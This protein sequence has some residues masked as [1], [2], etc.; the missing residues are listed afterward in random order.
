MSG[1]ANLPIE[2][3]VSV[4]KSSVGVAFADL[5]AKAASAGRKIGE[6]LSTKVSGTDSYK[7]LNTAFDN[8]QKNVA[9]G[10]AQ[11]NSFKTSEAKRASAIE[12]AQYKELNAAFDSYQKNVAQGVAQLNALKI[13]EAKKAAQAEIQAAKEVQA[14]LKEA[15]NSSTQSAFKAT[16]IRSPQDVATELAALRETKKAWEAMG[17]ATEG[18]KGQLDAITRSTNI[19]TEGN[20]RARGEFHQ[21]VAQLASWTFEVTA[22]AWALKNLGMAIASPALAGGKYLKEL[23]D[24]KLGITGVLMAMGHIDGQ[25]L[26]FGQASEVAEGQ[27]KLLSNEAM[28]LAGNTIDLAKAFQAVAVQGLEAGMTIDQIRT[29]AVAGTAAGRALGISAQTL[30]RDIRD[31]VLGIRPNSTI[32]SASLGITKADIDSARTSAGGLFEYLDGK[33]K[34]FYSAAMERNK[35]FSGMWEQMTEML[36]RALGGSSIEVFQ[37]AKDLVLQ[38]SDAIGKVDKNTHEFTVNPEF[39]SQLD[40]IIGLTNVL[41]KIVGAIAKF[42]WDMKIPLELWAGV[43]V[44]ITAWSLITTSITKATVALV[45]Y[46]TAQ[47]ASASVKAGTFVGPMQPLSSATSAATLASSLASVASKVLLVAAVATALYEIEKAAA[48]AFPPLQKLNDLISDQIDKFMEWGKY[49]TPLPKT[50]EEIDTALTKV[51]VTAVQDVAQAASTGGVVGLFL[52]F[53]AAGKEMMDTSGLEAQKKALQEASDKAATF[54]G[55]ITGAAKSVATL[56][57]ALKSLGDPLASAAD[58]ESKYLV[59]LQA[60]ARTKISIVEAKSRLEGL[61]QNPERDVSAVQ[62][63]QKEYN[64][65]I[66]SYT[67]AQ[68]TVN[69]KTQQSDLESKIASTNK[70]DSETAKIQLEYLNKRA[71]LEAKLVE[72][73]DMTVAQK[74]KKILNGNGKPMSSSDLVNTNIARQTAYNDALSETARIQ[75]LIDAN[76]AQEA[77]AI[78]NMPKIPRSPYKAELDKMSTVGIAANIEA[79]KSRTVAIAEGVSTN[80]AYVASQKNSSNME[81]VIKSGILGRLSEQQK[82]TLRQAAAAKDWEENSLK[83]VNAEQEQV[84]AIFSKEGAINQVD[85]IASKYF[86]TLSAGDQISQEF[87]LS[88]EKIS[89]PLGDAL[90]ILI[91]MRDAGNSSDGLAQAIAAI[92]EKLTKLGDVSNYVTK[93]LAPMLEIMQKIDQLKNA[94]DIKIE[95]IKQQ[96]LDLVPGGPQDRTPIEQ[97]GI[98]LSIYEA[99]NQLLR[100]TNAELEKMKALGVDTADVTSKQRKD[101]DETA[102]KVAS[103]RKE[104]EGY[105][106]AIDLSKSYGD[107]LYKIFDRAGSLFGG[108]AKPI[109]EVARSIGNLAGISETYTKSLE[110]AK[111]ISDDVHDPKRIEVEEA[112]YKKMSQESIGAYGDLAASA[113]GFFDNNSKGYSAMMGISK[114]F[115]MAE[116]AMQLATIPSKIMAGAAT[117]FGQSGWGGFV[118]VAAMGVVMAGLGYAMSGGSGGGAQIPQEDTAAYQQKTQGTGTVLGDSTAQSKTIT[119]GIEILSK[120]SFEMLD[121]TQSMLSALKRIDEG[122]SNLASSLAKISGIT[123]IGGVS[124]FGTVEKSSS[125]AGFLGIGATTDKTEIINTGILI[126]GTVDALTNLNGTIQQ[127]ETTAHSWSDS[128]FLGIGADSGVDINTQTKAITGEAVTQIGMIFG[129]MSDSI[130]EGINLLGMAANGSELEALMTTIG[131]TIIKGDASLMGL[132]GKDLTDA[133]NGVFSKAFDDMVGAIMPYAKDFQKIGEGIGETFIRLASNARTVD[134]A[135]TSMGMSFPSVA[136]YTKTHMPTAVDLTAV[137]NAQAKRDAV[138]ARLSASQQAD[139]AATPETVIGYTLKMGPSDGLDVFQFDTVMGKVVKASELTVSS[140]KE[141]IDADKDLAAAHLAAGDTTID[142]SHKLMIAREYLIEGAGGIDKFVESAQFFADKFLSESERLKPIAES[143]KSAFG[144]MSAADTA[145]GHLAGLGLQLKTLG[146]EVPT[147]KEEFKNI[148]LSLDLT[149]QSGADLYNS[150]MKVAP[151]FDAVTEAAKAFLE[152]LAS[153]M[154]SFS[155]TMSSFRGDSMIPMHQSE[156]DAAFVKLNKLAPW[157]KSIQQLSTITSADFGN[158]SEEAR[159]AILATLKA[160]DTLKNDY[161]QATAQASE[162]ATQ[163][164]QAAKDAYK[165]AL[166]SQQ[167]YFV[168][169]VDFGKSIKTFLDQLE[170]NPNTAISPQ[171]QLEAARNQYIADLTKAKAGDYEAAKN[172]TQTAQTYIDVAKS[173]YGNGSEQSAILSQI[174]AELNAL[175][176]VAQYDANLA[177][178]NSLDAKLVTLDNSTATVNTSINTIGVMITKAIEVS[179]QVLTSAYSGTVSDTQAAGFTFNPA[180]GGYNWDAMNSGS[181]GWS[182]FAQTNAVDPINFMPMHSDAYSGTVSDTQAAANLAAR[183]AINRTIGSAPQFASGGDFT[184]GVRLVGEYGPELEITGPSRIYSADQTRNLLTKPN[185]N[186]SEDIILE[187][188]MLR[189][190]L[191]ETKITLARRLEQGNSKISEQTQELSSVMY[192]TSNSVV[193]GTKTAALLKDTA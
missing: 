165:S 137:T 69:L 131:N 57:D 3:T 161:A 99:R 90:A 26:T 10:V 149:S 153:D 93:T 97:S 8:Y 169:L 73:Q 189:A 171:S 159:A 176:P 27:V 122:I 17:P 54:S 32:L 34:G 101:Y 91:S 52:A 36:N 156:L 81:E 193:A 133:L 140:T 16:G 172:I 15:Q 28:F 89:K 179:T 98:D 82:L 118:G 167:A 173:F 109:A 170:V 130:K 146:Y 183:Q 151:A 150:M 124:A 114:A 79:I 168:G 134:L 35:T 59:M 110:Q 74:G 51:Q 30:Q 92:I 31:M 162:Q 138:A 50:L 39:K 41:L 63:A 145:T 188:Q 174:K 155:T 191:A 132:K 113:A 37:T 106:K 107:Q 78:A 121:Y 49:A 163:A 160:A 45:E 85:A 65:L 186:D 105:A 25:V 75:K 62:A 102:K 43:Q 56:K 29:I 180:N 184:G 2:I 95:A 100:E 19:L 84:K 76:M 71:A 13:A 152:Q 142:M 4:D 42:I 7:E 44:G 119:N 158:Y 116:M 181:G 72:A 144:D 38:L 103:L 60:A 6:S 129:S 125:S 175:S 77:N 20:A 22:A 5:E 18:Y 192:S 88:A 66:S 123:G 177:A 115:H 136:E 1:N 70:L 148:V 11:L 80:E 128:G 178:L 33:L 64:A 111:L 147:T 187:L 83:I 40:A 46:R 68:A 104:V 126:R 14:A 143:V 47:I 164:A 120:H 24:V 53:V 139:I 182:Q 61:T 108:M 67:V 87:S 190:E 112:A 94:S 12:A 127:F 23:E 154:N 117:M 9:Q 58:Q 21:F 166:E 157:I 141:L 55:S 96:P 86:K 135:L 185:N 48:A